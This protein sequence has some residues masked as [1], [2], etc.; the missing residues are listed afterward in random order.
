MEKL[1]RGGVRYCQKSLTW[2]CQVAGSGQE[3]RKL[4]SE[5]LSLHFCILVVSKEVINEE[6]NICT[7]F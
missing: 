5:F 6:I 2:R 4:P 7:E 1:V 3:L